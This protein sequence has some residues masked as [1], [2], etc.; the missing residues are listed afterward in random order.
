MIMDEKYVI[1]IGRQF[2]SGGYTIARHLAERLGIKFFDKELLALAAKE[3]GFK[4]SLFEQKDEKKSLFDFICSVHTVFDGGHAVYGN[5]LSDESLFKI[6]SDVIVKQA[7]RQSCLFVG[8]CADYILRNHPRCVNIFIAADPA[9]R[10]KRISQRLNV[11]DTAARKAIEKADE[12][13]SAYYNYYSCNTWGAAATY[14]LCVNSSKMG[15]EKTEDLLIDFIRETLHLE[16][17]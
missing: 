4:E 13:R 1:T 16:V 6:Q 12:Q 2:G 15:F 5:C 10:V 11:D 3:S 8:R 17:K 9:D 7:A 14:H